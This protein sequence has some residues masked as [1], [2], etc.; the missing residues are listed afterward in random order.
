MKLCKTFVVS[1]LLL[2]ICSLETEDRVT[3]NQTQDS[4]PKQATERAQNIIRRR[5]YGWGMNP[6]MGLGM[7]STMGNPYMG[8]GMANPY[9]ASMNPMY[10]VGVNGMNNPQLMNTNVM[11]PYSMGM[12]FPH[13]MGV[14]M[15]GLGMNTMMNPMGYMGA[16]GTPML[17]YMAA[18]N[19]FLLGPFGLGSGLTMGGYFPGAFGMNQQQNPNLYSQQQRYPRKLPVLTIEADKVQKI[20][21]KFEEALNELKALMGTGNENQTP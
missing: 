13:M 20:S 1:M 21:D 18:M 3:A 6:F 11:N 9:M 8:A 16:M 10:Q 15:A 5:L 19:P 4:L 2:T 14:G 12:M 17:N 7:M